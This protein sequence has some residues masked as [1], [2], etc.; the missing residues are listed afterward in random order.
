VFVALDR[1]AFKPGL[2][3]MPLTASVVMRVIAQGMRGGHPAQESAHLAVLRRAQNQMPVVRHQGKSENLHRIFREA[4]SQDP[5]EG[6][7]ILVFVEDGLTPVAA[8]EGM[9]DHASF[10]NSWLPWHC[11]LVLSGENRQDT[12]CRT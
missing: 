3:E 7:V 9:V 2:I 10:I 12:R 6:F 11:V 8:I 4:L 1:K 5:D